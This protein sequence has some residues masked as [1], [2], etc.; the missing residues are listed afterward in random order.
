MKAV[1]IILCIVLWFAVRE[2]SARMRLV[3]IKNLICPLSFLCKEAKI[4]HRT[5]SKK[6]LCEIG[7]EAIWKSRFTCFFTY[8]VRDEK[9]IKISNDHE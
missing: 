1:H 3:N 4:K 2:R 5:S 6:E 8:F 7:K 9:V